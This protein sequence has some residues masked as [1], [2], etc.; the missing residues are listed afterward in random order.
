MDNRLGIRFGFLVHDVSRLRRT[1]FD[2]RS[3]HLDITRSEAWI[4]TGISRRADGQSQTELARVLGLGKVA[5]G[6]FVAELERKGLVV[7]RVLSND[8]RTYR[9]QLTRRGSKMLARISVI[10][11]Q[12]NAEIFADFSQAEVERLE[13]D[14][15]RL[16]LNLKA[17]VDS[18]SAARLGTGRRE[19]KA[20]QVTRRSA[21]AKLQRKMTGG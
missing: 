17:A 10:V 8:R 4:L 7:R 18:D 2:I 20:A 5:T 15:R 3:Q 14:L 9:V 21:V 13:S 12:I 16:K 19:T 11:L 6:E 1:L